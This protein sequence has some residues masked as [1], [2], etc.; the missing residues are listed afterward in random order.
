MM[1]KALIAPDI[2]DKVW[3]DWLEQQS[4]T[5]H[6]RSWVLGRP[7][8]AGSR[9]M[10]KRQRFEDWLFSQGATIKRI[11]KQFYIEFTDPKQASFFLLRWS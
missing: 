7:F 5:A 9:R 10:N 6:E 8:G 2:L 11:N 3:N 1:K 4:L